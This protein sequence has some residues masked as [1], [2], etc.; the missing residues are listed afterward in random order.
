[1]IDICNLLLVGHEHSIRALGEELREQA[2]E[3]PTSSRRVNQC[4]LK[5]EAIVSGSQNSLSKSC[6]HAK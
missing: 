2:L 4:S 1:M 6:A 5:L 3:P